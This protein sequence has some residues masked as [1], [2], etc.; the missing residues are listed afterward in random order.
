MV[1]ISQNF[2]AFS[3]YMN[4]NCL[5]QKI[6]GTQMNWTKVKFQNGFRFNGNWIGNSWCD[7]WDDFLRRFLGWFLG[8]FWVIFGVIMYICTYFCFKS[9]RNSMINITLLFQASQHISISKW[10]QV[11]RELHRQELMRERERKIAEE[12]KGAS[13]GGSQS[14]RN[15]LGGGTSH[16]SSGSLAGLGGAGGG[17]GGLPQ[18]ESRH[19]S[20]HERNSF[21]TGLQRPP[22]LT[23]RQIAVVSFCRCFLDVFLIFRCYSWKELDGFF[24]F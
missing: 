18:P 5:R 15:G 16:G 4:F 10:F 9:V 8:W 7:F 23:K 19:K 22:P 13:S 14:G 6:T 2:V 21:K 11:E 12:L 17:G 20:D 24:L 3:E 1:E